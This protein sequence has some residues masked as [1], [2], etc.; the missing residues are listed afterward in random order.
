MWE[1][2]N[3]AARCFLLSSALLINQWGK[4]RKIYRTDNPRKNR[5]LAHYPLLELSRAISGRGE[6]RRS[7]SSMKLSLTILDLP[8]RGQ[9]FPFNASYPSAPTPDHPSIAFRGSQGP[10]KRS[11]SRGQ[12]VR[13]RENSRV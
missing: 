6:Y 9:F 5:V 10:A 8:W 4:K 1:A 13:K 11:L 3:P 7:Y 2:Q 12:R